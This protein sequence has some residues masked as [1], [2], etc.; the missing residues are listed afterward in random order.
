MHRGTNGYQKRQG[1]RCNLRTV[2]TLPAWLRARPSP[3]VSVPLPHPRWPLFPQKP[4]QRS[5]AS[6]GRPLWFFSMEPFPGLTVCCRYWCGTP[7]GLSLSS[8]WVLRPGLYLVSTHRHQWVQEA[9]TVLSSLLWGLTLVPGSAE[10]RHTGRLRVTR[11]R[12]A[13][14]IPGRPHS[15]CTKPAVQKEAP[16]PRWATSWAHGPRGSPAW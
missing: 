3:G 16:H 12:M 8:A 9:V 6:L 2:S 11:T 15:P 4:V 14:V 1:A 13:L 5:W 7:R 10:L